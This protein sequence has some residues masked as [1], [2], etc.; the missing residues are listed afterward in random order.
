[1]QVVTLPYKH[2]LDVD[3]PSEIRPEMVTISAKKGDRLDIVADAWHKEN[4]CHYEWQIRF[5]PHDI[6][7]S[8]V[9]A[10]VTEGHLTIDVQ[11][12]RSTR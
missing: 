3:L 1:M 9:H 7:M 5:P 11:R 2:T 8:S 4:D 12:R 10:K 6:D